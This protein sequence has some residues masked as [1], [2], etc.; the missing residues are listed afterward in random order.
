MAEQLLPAELQ[1]CARAAVRMVRK[2]QIEAGGGAGAQV[3]KAKAKTSADDDMQSV[4]SDSTWTSASTLPTRPAK[5]GSQS[6]PSS[7]KTGALF[8]AVCPETRGTLPQIM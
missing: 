2:K 8:G 4:A 1:E 6:W 7:S 3:S 5:G